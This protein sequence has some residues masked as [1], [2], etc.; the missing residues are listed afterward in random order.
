ML[1]GGK[2]LK[3]HCLLQNIMHS[4]VLDKLNDILFK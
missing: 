2:K 1:I 4:F 3:Y